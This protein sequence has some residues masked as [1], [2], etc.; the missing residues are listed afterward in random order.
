MTTICV[1]GAAGYIGSTL[2]KYLL[3]N[4]FNVIALDSFL[5]SS[6]SLNCLIGEKNFHVAKL[7][8]RDFDEIKKFYDQS[9][10]II[11]LACLVGAPLCE[12]KKQEAQEVN[13]SSIK[14][15]KDNC[16]KNQ[17]IIYPTTNSGYGVGESGQYCTEE[18]PLNPISHYGKTKVSAERCLEEIENSIR[19]RL[20]TVFGVS[21][22]MRLDLLVNDFVYKAHNDKY[23]VLFES[24]FKR[25]YIHVND[26]CRAFLHAIENINIFKGNTYNLGLSTANLSKMELCEKIKEYYKDFYIGKSEFGKDLDKR[27]Y[28][29]SNEKIEKTGYIPKF[30]LDDGIVEL[31]KLF[32]ILHVNGSMRN[33]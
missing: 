5:Y 3:D 22:R 27:D 33:F 11:P 19:F 23:I 20:A 8:V 25:N 13:Y 32:K 4:K 17:L 18:T 15:L 30:S 10:I 26:V 21:P 14:F 1:T 6:S 31:Q 24:H 28:I 29:V 9:D 2:C 7:D 12:F 16:S